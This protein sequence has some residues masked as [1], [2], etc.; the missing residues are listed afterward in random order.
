[1]NDVSLQ[2]QLEGTQHILGHVLETIG[3]PVSVPKARLQESLGGR[4]MIEMVETEDAFVF[5][6][7]EVTDEQ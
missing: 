3:E 2:K 4:Y 7:E 6:L 5:S 1:M